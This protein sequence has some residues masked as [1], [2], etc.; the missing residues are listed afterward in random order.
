MSY[1]VRYCYKRL[2]ID[3]KN[4][5]RLEN[6]TILQSFQY[7]KNVPRRYNRE[8]GPIVSVGVDPTGTFWLRLPVRRVNR[9][10]GN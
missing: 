3:M 9:L 5:T 4:S 10:L 6:A 8:R 7:N 1:F 2:D